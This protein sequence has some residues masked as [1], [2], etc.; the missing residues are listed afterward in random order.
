MEKEGKQD[1]TNEGR[2]N[3]GQ[4]SLRNEVWSEREVFGKVR[5]QKESR[6]IEKNEMEIVLELYIE[7]HDSRWIKRCRDLNFDRYSYREVSTAKRARWIEKLS[8]SY[9][10]DRNFLDGM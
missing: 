2:N 4:K 5:S 6:E 10:G 1:L 7:I 3:L 8:S 9:R